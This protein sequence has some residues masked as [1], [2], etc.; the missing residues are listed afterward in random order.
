MYAPPS[1]LRRYDLFLID[2]ASQIDN[3]VAQRLR[4]ALS[5]L[6]HRPLVVVA[7]DYRQLQPIEGGGEMARWCMEMEH[8]N[9]TVVHRTDDPALLSFLQTIRRDQPTRQCLRGF[10]NADRHL[11]MDLLSAVRRG[12]DEQRRRGRHF[13][14]LCVTNKG[15]DEVNSMALLLEG[16]KD[17]ERLEGY[18]GD[19]NARAGKMFI[20]PGL[21]VRLTRNLDKTR[22]FV[23]GALGQA[24]DVLCQDN[25][26]VTAFTARLS[27]GAMVLVHPIRIRQEVFMPCCYGYA[28]TMRR[29]QGSSLFCGALYFNHKYPP[30]PGYGYVGASRFRSSDGIFLYGKIRR[31]DWIPVGK[32]KPEWDLRRSAASRS[33]S[34]AHDS[35]YGSDSEDVRVDSSSSEES[36]GMVV[37]SASEESSIPALPDPEDYETDSD[38][39]PAV[40]ESENFLDR[41]RE[42]DDVAVSYLDDV[43]SGVDEDDLFGPDPAP[44]YTDTA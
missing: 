4:I 28:T 34:S 18:N 6:P 22:G 35:G 44:R 43:D 16:V 13:M 8:F 24:V 32:P 36:S 37:E 21:W 26:G 40:G 25:V 1:R 2:E 27:T 11:P 42:G 17:W 30:D 29:A 23:N 10:W 33:T 20:K 41:V 38:L 31:S 19:P 9:L 12:R 5:E 7:G 3:P 14:W 39:E 15:A